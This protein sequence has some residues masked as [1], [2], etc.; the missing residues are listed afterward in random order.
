MHDHLRDLGREM[1]NELSPPRRVWH[2]QHIKSLII[3]CSALEKLAG[4]S[5]LSFLKTIKIKKCGKLNCLE[6]D[7]C[8]NLKRVDVSDLPKLVILSIHHCPELKK[9]SNLYGL[10][11]LEQI[12]IDGC[13][14]LV[15]LI[16]TECGN[17]L[18]LTLAGLNFLQTIQIERCEKLQNIAG[19]EELLALKAM[20]MSLCNNAAMKQYGVPLT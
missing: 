14:K 12:T 5:H 8:A 20:E 3:E 11:S 4:L 15:Q 13:S 7:D 18:E 1:A 10:S 16:I 17:L 6:L 2:P 9:L 19:I